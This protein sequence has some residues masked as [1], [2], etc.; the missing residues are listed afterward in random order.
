MKKHK[1]LS[2]LLVVVLVLAVMLPLTGCGS[3]PVKPVELVDTYYSNTRMKVLTPSGMDKQY[4][5]LE[6]FSVSLY[7]DNTYVCQI[8]ITESLSGGGD[9]EVSYRSIRNI[10]AF[11]RHGTYELVK[12]EADGTF[13]LKLGKA[14]RIIFALNGGHQQLDPGTGYSYIDSANPATIENFEAQW[15]W[16]G[17]WENFSNL[18][19]AEATLN[20]NLETHLFDENAVVFEYRTP[21]FAFLPGGG[22]LW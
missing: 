3:D 4:L 12:N 11:T 6:T 22:D 15:E 14:D 7:S 8:N 9:A 16:Y 17:N 20:G 1:S 5:V 2:A 19:G 18:V 21:N 13:S 10:N